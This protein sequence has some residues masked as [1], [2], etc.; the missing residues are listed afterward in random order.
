MDFSYITHGM[1]IVYKSKRQ[2]LLEK[3][4]MLE[5]LIWL[6]EQEEKLD[7]DK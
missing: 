3:L 7:D 6:L 4:E 5:I 2:E 1:P